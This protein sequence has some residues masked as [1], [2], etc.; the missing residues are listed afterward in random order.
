MQFVHWE[1]IGIMIDIM[2]MISISKGNEVFVYGC[3]NIGDIYIYK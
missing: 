3:V 1:F 2:N